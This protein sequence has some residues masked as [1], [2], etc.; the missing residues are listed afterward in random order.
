MVELDDEAFSY[1][2]DSILERVK[3][4]MLKYVKMIE[5]ADDLG[6]LY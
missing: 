4:Y 5:I 2:R 3:K 1:I 6:D